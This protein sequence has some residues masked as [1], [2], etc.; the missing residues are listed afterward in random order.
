MEYSQEDLLWRE[1]EILQSAQYGPWAHDL[2]EFTGPCPLGVVLKAKA[3]S[4]QEQMRKTKK[5]EE[6]SGISH[7]AEN[8]VCQPHS[9]AGIGSMKMDLSKVL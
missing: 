3:L 8:K 2:C 6:G 4:F 7:R 1:E 9:F 5:D